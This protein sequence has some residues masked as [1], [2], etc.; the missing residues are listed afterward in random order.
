MFHDIS[1]GSISPGGRGDT[2]PSAR[3]GGGGKNYPRKKA[4][5]KRLDPLPNGNGKGK[6][7]VKFAPDGILL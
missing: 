1:M 2:P 3:S 6:H 4:A 5:G 7:K